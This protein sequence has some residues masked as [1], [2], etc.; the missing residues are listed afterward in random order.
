MVFQEHIS[1]KLY[2]KMQIQL[3]DYLSKVSGL[4]SNKKAKWDFR[5]KHLNVS[6]LK[7]N[8]LKMVYSRYSNGL[9]LECGQFWD[10]V[11]RHTA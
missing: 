4:I 6:I 11:W 3:N 2:M 8:S 9:M 7:V 10:Q 1:D 5:K